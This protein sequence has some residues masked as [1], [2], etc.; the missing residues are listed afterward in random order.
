[1]VIGGPIELKEEAPDE[2]T[3]QLQSTDTASAGAQYED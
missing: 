3:A 2:L 1:L